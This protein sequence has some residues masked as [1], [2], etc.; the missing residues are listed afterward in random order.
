[1]EDGPYD[2]EGGGT[3]GHLDYIYGYLWSLDFEVSDHQDFMKCLLDVVICH[4]SGVDRWAGGLSNHV[5]L[6]KYILEFWYYKPI[7]RL[8]VD[9][10]Q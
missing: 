6:A 7:S 10:E 4:L 8:L 3:S 2:H 1:M 5:L 9:F